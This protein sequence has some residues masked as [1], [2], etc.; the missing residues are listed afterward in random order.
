MSVYT[1]HPNEFWDLT[2]EEQEELENRFASGEVVGS[3]ATQTDAFN[4]TLSTKRRVSGMYRWD[5]DYGEFVK[6]V[7]TNP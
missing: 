5:S 6:L 2:K 4:I 7:I 1:G 3:P